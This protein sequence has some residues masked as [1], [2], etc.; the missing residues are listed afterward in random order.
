MMKKLR[1][2]LNYSNLTATIALILA[3]GGAGAVAAGSIGKNSVGT[4]QLKNNAVTA[5]KIRNGAV[6]P[7]KMANGSVTNA[8]IQGSAVT[9]DKIADGSVTNAKIQGGAVTGDKVD[10]ATLGKVPSAAQADSAT[11]ADNGAKP[12]LF[13]SAGGDS[14]PSP[15]SPG[16]HRILT[17]GRLNID[18][19]CVNLTLSEGRAYVTMASS[20]NAPISWATIQYKNPGDFPFTD[21]TVIGPTANQNFAVSN[22]EGGNKLEAGQWFFHSGNEVI[23]VTMNVGLAGLGNETCSI[24]GTAIRAA[25]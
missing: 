23:T 6:T 8:K 2:R 18:A 19:S 9:S 21:G 16:A 1:G 17:L 7:G 22:L 20:V 12:I 5:K 4:K 25:S 10:T 14:N 15:G 11:S 13:I 24:I 3:V